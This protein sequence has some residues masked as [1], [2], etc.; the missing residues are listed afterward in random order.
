[1]NHYAH[2]VEKLNTSTS[3]NL[4]EATEIDVSDVKI[5]AK[6]N[7]FFKSAKLRVTSAWDGIHGT[8]VMTESTHPLG[9]LRL[10]LDDIKKLSKI[11]ELRWMEPDS[12][13]SGFSFG[14]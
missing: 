2:I 11:K 14:I 3:H 8:I 1:M 5:P 9:G 4:N 13:G 12:S 7:A 6:L 10:T